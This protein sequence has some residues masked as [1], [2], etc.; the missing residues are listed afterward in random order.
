MAEGQ[1][2]A[3]VDGKIVENLHVAT[4][5]A[6]LPRP[7]QSHRWRRSNGLSMADT[8][9]GRAVDRRALFKRLRPTGAPRWAMRARAWSPWRIFSPPVVLMVMGYRMGAE[10]VNVWYPTQPS[11]V[12]QQPA[13]ADRRF[14]SSPPLGA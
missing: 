11:R 3:V 7:R 10:F 4:A 12:H 9:W 5:R 2:V 8:H 6:T 1:G 14:T 13:D